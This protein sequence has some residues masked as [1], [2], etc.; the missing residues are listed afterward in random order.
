M[1]CG[2]DGCICGHDEATL[3]EGVAIVGTE[4]TLPV[5][6]EDHA[7]CCGGHDGGGHAGGCHAD[8]A[9]HADHAPAPSRG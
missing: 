6:G 7:G 2:H 4:T 5:A 9:D 8:H 1:S 3:D